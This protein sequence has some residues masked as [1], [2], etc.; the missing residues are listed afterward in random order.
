[1]AQSNLLTVANA[2]GALAAEF[3]NNT[4]L[5]SNIKLAM[6]KCE[7]TQKKLSLYIIGEI[8]KLSKTPLQNEKSLIDSLFKLL[9]TESEE[10]K[11]VCAI[12]IGRLSVSNPKYF[13]PLIFDSI[14]Q[15]G[16]SYLMLYAIRE[17]ILTNAKILEPFL[18]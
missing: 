16:H 8:G 2:I 6:G 9:N 14:K 7:V 12:C 3:N 10:I 15:K 13:V 1:L 11:S 5:D 17:V 18:D 4:I